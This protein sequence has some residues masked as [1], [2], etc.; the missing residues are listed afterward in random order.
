MCRDHEHG[1]RRCRCCDP[2]A[3]R[4]DRRE[5][6]MRERGHEGEVDAA[7]ASATVAERAAMADEHPEAVYDPSPTV[8]TAAAR[9]PVTE[10]VEDVLAGDESPRVRRG[11]ASNPGCSAET[12]DALSGD[13]DQGVREAVARNQRTPPEALE[14]M[15]SELDRRR[16]LGVARALATNPNTPVAA[17][18]AW[19]DHGTG[20]WKTLARSALRARAQA[21][22]GAVLAS[23]ER[24][25]DSIEEAADATAG[26][27]DDLLSRKVG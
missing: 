13:E 2:E 11:L 3:R 18:E 6:R 8:R 15:A 1:P 24:I 21:A 10:E 23:T 19:L 20:G 4:A 7:Y 27:L 25:G 22:A 5:R 16:D 26:G 12:L 9:G 14:D 17:L